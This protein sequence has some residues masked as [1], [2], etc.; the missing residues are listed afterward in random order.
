MLTHCQVKYQT[1]DTFV[2]ELS[3]CSVLQVSY[4]SLGYVVPVQQD[5]L[6]TFETS[7]RVR[8]RL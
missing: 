2:K 6:L 4:H 3:L 5:L 8:P 1:I 7:S